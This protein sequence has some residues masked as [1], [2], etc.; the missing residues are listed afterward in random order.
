VSRATLEPYRHGAHPPLKAKGYRIRKLFQVRPAILIHSAEAQ[1]A[2]AF[3]NKHSTGNQQTPTL[4]PVVTGR[5]YAMF[6]A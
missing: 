1:G 3:P 5:S 4:S 6:V 2:T